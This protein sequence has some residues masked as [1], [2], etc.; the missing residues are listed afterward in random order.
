[1]IVYT[2]HF[3]TKCFFPYERDF[4]FSNCIF[5]PREHFFPIS[6]CWGF[7]KNLFSCW[8]QQKCQIWIK[9]LHPGSILKLVWVGWS[10][11]N[12]TPM[13]VS[14]PWFV[15]TKLKAV[16]SDST[17]RN[18]GDSEQVSWDA[19][20]LHDSTVTQILTFPAA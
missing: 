5:R 10:S 12:I 11:T 16:S 19:K 3:S 13:D 20:I 15:N 4:C 1:M 18:S 14:V 17:N 2:I 8:G 6:F 9:T 7:F